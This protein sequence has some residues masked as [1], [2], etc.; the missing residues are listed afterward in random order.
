[1]R[2]VKIDSKNNHETYAMDM[3]GMG[4]LIRSVH[5]FQ[6]NVQAESMVQVP[7]VKLVNGKLEAAYDLT[8][9]ADN[10]Q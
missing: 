8:Q 6:G 4:V 2:W 1:M 9:L 3:A 7:G 5:A 10:V